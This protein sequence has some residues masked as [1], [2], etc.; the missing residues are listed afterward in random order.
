MRSKNYIRIIVFSLIVLFLFLWIITKPPSPQKEVNKNVVSSSPGTSSIVWKAPDTNEIPET[1]EGK[2]IR[3]G[4]ELIM[5]TGK[6][7]GPK[8]IISPQANG[9]NC[10]NCHLYGGTK[11]FGN[12]FSMVASTYPKFRARNGKVVTIADRVNGCMERSMNGRSLDTLSKEMKAIVAYMNWIG[13]DVSKKKKILGSG[14]G[15]LPYLNRAADPSK[16]KIV[17]ISSCSK[18]HGKNGEGV[19]N[20]EATEYFFPPLWGPHSY[21]IGAGIYRVSNFAGFVKNNM[22]FGVT[23]NY[24][25]LSNE[26]AW[27]VAAYVNSQAHPYKNCSKDWPVLSTKPIDYPFGPYADNWPEQRHKYGPFVNA[28]NQLTDKK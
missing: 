27:D 24:P 26:E 21:N 4:R 22:P 5:H 2:M 10:Q 16:G 11:L 12:N 1:P 6:Y 14:T 19:L 13:K 17:Y 15:G 28:N 9:L 8:G 25:L 3:Y 7:L 20:N 23:H 18:C